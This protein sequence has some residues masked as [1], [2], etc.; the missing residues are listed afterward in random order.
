MSSAKWVVGIVGMALL[1]PALMLAKDSNLKS[2]QNLTQLAVG[3]EI[4]ITK[5]TGKPLRGAFICFTEHSISLREKQREIAILRTE[6]VRVQ[7][8]PSDRHKCLWS[9][10]AIGAGA[11][12]GVGLGIGQGVANESGG[13]FRNLKPAITTVSA[14]LGALVGAGIGSAF[15]GRHTTIYIAP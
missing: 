5:T 13:D 2:W 7:L 8:R 1:D 9:G 4:E 3:Q 11:G 6:V 12:A 14:V 10:A 15:G